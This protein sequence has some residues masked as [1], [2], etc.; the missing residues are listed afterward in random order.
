MIH[1][2]KHMAGGAPHSPYD[3]HG[4][5]EFFANKIKDAMKNWNGLQALDVGT[6]S[7]A[8]AIYLSELVG[9]KGKVYSVDPSRE[10]LQ[11]AAR[12]IAE[13]KLSKRIELV[14]GKAEKLPLDDSSFDVIVTLMTLHHLENTDKAFQEFSRVL[15]RDGAYLAVE[16][17]SKASAFIPHPSAD[18][19]SMEEVRRKLE[20]ARFNVTDLEQSN[21][22]FFIKAQKKGEE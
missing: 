12:I 15:N 20:N 7:A 22:S 6:G 17:T 21:Y 18:F 19:L 14:E 1:K 9:A 13:K 2:G 4:F 3:M 16:W 10:I 11:N 5:G 8:N